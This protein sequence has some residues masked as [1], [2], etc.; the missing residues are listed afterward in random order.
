MSKLVFLT[1]ERERRCGRWREETWVDLQ[2]QE[3]DAARD[4]ASEVRKGEVSVV[5]SK[6]VSHASFT[7]ASFTVISR[8]R[9]FSWGC[10]YLLFGTTA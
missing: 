4:G 5:D 9:N 8:C 6:C 2:Q 3:K 10:I 1:E 7:Q